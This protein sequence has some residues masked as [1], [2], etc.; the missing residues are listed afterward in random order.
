MPPSPT[1]PPSRS[2]RR[3]IVLSAKI[4]VAVAA[5]TGLAQWATQM[6]SGG[7]PASVVAARTVIDPATTGTVGSRAPVAPRV[8]LDQNHL[9]SLVSQ[10]QGG[11]P[12]P[13]PARKR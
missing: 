11:A 9:T 7:A 5:L 8:E 13:A 3:W 4:A 6:R 2:R 1:S 10:A 12:K